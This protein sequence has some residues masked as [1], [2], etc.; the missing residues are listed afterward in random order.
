[1]NIKRVEEL[2]QAGRMRPAGLAA[3]QAR[4]QAKKQRYSYEERPRQFDEAYEQQFRQHPKAWEF[5]RS[6]TPS[7]QRV[8]I[9]YV[10]SAKKEETR[11]KRLATLIEVSENRKR[12]PQFNRTGAGE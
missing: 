4:E 12:L 7:Y 11:Q 1:M 6:Q 3:F 2:T 8:A 10:I 5:F 9:W